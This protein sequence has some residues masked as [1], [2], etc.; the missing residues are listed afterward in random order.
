MPL[1]FQSRIEEADLDLNPS[2]YYIFGDNHRRTG[3][4]GLAAICRGKPN[5]IGI[6]TKKAPLT[7]ATAYLTDD[8][9]DINKEWIDE[10]MDRVVQYLFEGRVVVFPVAPL[11][12]GLAELDKR[13]P[14]TY[15]YLRELVETL[16]DRYG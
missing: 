13:A 10:D 6:R 1:L 8:E 12:S 9:Y 5:T 3:R 11:G 4:G 7:N 16:A 15:Q 14:K 2:V